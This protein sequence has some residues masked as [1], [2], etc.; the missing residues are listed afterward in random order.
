MRTSRPRPRSPIVCS[1]FYDRRVWVARE[2]ARLLVRTAVCA[3]VALG[4]AAILA[5]LSSQ[6]FHSD[7]RVLCIVI[8]CMLLAM[9]GVGRG[10]NLERYMDTNVTKVTWGVV[11]GF[12]S[13]KRRPE[14]P[15]LAPGAAF[16]C[17]GIAVIAIGVLL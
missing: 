1:H 8:G 17:S 3:A 13:F 9:A 11:P 6:H 5:A 2:L 12:D 10:S 15:T 16:L 4:L 7:A 14:D